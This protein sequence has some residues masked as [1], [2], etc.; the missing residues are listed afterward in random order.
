MQHTMRLNAQPFQSIR[1]GLKTIELRLYDEKRKRIAVGDHIVFTHTDDATQ[2]LRCLVVAVH[3]FASFEQLYAALPLEKC[4]YTRE[5]LAS[6]SPKDMQAYYSQEQQKQHG[7][8][9]LELKLL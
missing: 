5:Q 6:A 2:T 9:G 1:D 4:G 7:V 8:V 3:V